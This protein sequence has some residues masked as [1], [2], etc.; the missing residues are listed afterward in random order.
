[1]IELDIIKIGCIF[2]YHKGFYNKTLNLIE[3]YFDKLYSSENQEV[4]ED[5][6]II[7]SNL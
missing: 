4:Y 6:I 2:N 7:L 1:M 5:I 3:R